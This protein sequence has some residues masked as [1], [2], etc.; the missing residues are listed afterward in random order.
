[1]IPAQSSGAT[2]RA[3]SASGIA[4]ANAAGATQYSAKPPSTCQPVKRGSEQRFSSPRAQKR[5]RPHARCS[6]ATPTRAPGAIDAPA[7]GAHDAAD[8]L[9][10]GHD[11]GPLRRQLAF[12]HV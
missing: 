6:H 9:M 2:S 3:G 12:D 8:D 4:Y 1:M 5:Q 7:S 11:H 10:A